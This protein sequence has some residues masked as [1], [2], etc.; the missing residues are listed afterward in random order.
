MLDMSRQ[1]CTCAICV[2]GIRHKVE[3]TVLFYAC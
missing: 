1:E 3:R 2:S